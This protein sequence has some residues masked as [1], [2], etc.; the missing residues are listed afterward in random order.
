MQITKN[1]KLGLCGAF[2]ASCMASPSHRMLDSS[3]RVSKQDEAI[4]LAGVIAR[5]R[6][7]NAANMAITH[8]FLLP[9]ESSL[10]PKHLP[11]RAH[12]RPQ[13]TAPLARKHTPPERERTSWR[14]SEKEWGG[15]QR[16]GGRRVPS[17][18][19]SSSSSSSRGARTAAVA[20]AV[21]PS[22]VDDDDGARS[23]SQSAEER[24]DLFFVG[25][26]ALCIVR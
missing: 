26:S 11:R 21:A 12:S 13:P 7:R 22:A 3:K 17:S 14:G 2:T 5:C 18:S 19:S 6:S 9:S 15:R 8:H 23:V 25:V 24:L 10:L 4:L 20:A 1:K 16:G